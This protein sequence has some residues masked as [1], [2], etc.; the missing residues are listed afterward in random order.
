[1][2]NDSVLTV[3]EAA[4]ILRISPSKTYQL[5]RSNQ[6]PHIS[7]GKRYIIPREPLLKWLASSVKGG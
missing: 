7:M 4:A 3:K 6:I 5:I 1:M 2:D